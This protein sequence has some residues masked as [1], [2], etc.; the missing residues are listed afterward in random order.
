MSGAYT[1]S[2]TWEPLSLTYTAPAG[3]VSLRLDI[4]IET[5]TGEVWF[6]N[7]RFNVARYG[8]LG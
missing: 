5:S 6:D 2:D 8:A 7:I 4:A 1:L 3:C